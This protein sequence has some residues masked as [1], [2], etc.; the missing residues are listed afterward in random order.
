MLKINYMY[1]S[2]F[3]IEKHFS[4]IFLPKILEI[5]LMQHK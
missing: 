4:E 5:T 2:Y 1:F 3:F